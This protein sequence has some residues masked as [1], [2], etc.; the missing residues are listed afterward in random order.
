MSSKQQ[1]KPDAGASSPW[2]GG[3]LEIGGR[4]AGAFAQAQLMNDVRSLA[5]GQWQWT[6]WLTPKGR[7]Q[8][9]GALLRLDAERYWWLLPDA[10]PGPLAEAL[11][12][13]VF[14]S[15]VR[16]EPRGESSMRGYACPP[17]ALG[18]SARGAQAQ[19]DGPR[20][21]LDLSG[22]HPRSLLLDAS[23]PPAREDALDAAGW[24]L[25]DLAHG[26]PRLDP[27]AEPAHTPQM[28]GLARLGAYSVKKGC[29]PGQEIV[30]RTHFLG[31]AKRGLQRLHARRPLADGE[32]LGSAAGEQPVLC[33]AA[34]SER[35]EALAV[36]PLEAGAASWHADPE[37]PV[38]VIPF[39]EGLA[40]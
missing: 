16:L 28:L 7:V 38:D 19:G 21:V 25:E 37:T 31:Q 10:A 22:E 2:R 34:T 1:A 3:V 15:K 14:R 27:A 23:D 18:S 13:F 36:L 33:A 26:L 24:A 9:L 32:V 8:A 11:Q 12:R 17:A 40:R 4:D 39:A 20:W 6:G 35:W 30:A 5:D 29:Y